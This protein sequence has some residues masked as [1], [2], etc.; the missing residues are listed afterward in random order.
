LGDGIPGSPVPLSGGGAAPTTAF[1]TS[2]LSVGTHSIT[3]QYAGDN[4]HGA[5]AATVVQTVR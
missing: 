1:T 5:A 3:A 2:V 4:Q